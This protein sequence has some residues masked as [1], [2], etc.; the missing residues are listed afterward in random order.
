MY[1]H[2]IT[3]SRDS[4]STA[5]RLIGPEKRETENESWKRG[6]VNRHNGDGRERW[7]VSMCQSLCGVSVTGLP[8]S[9]QNKTATCKVCSRAVGLAWRGINN[10]TQNKN[11][12]QDTR[13]HNKGENKPKWSKN[14]S[15]SNK[16][17][18]ENK[19]KQTLLRGKV[20][21]PPQHGNSAPQK[22]A[23]FPLKLK[24][25]TQLSYQHHFITVKKAHTA[26]C[27]IKSESPNQNKTNVHASVITIFELVCLSLQ[28]L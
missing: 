18:E 13:K 5:G 14:T 9:E 17:R 22:P 26:L 2:I 10:G 8:I 27:T 28:A 7:R 12:T 11:G 4:G 20:I 23:F 3:D 15:S 21:T 6:E 16:K 19:R 1:K 25:C 24:K